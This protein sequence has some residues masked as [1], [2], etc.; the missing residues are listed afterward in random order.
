MKITR[1]KQKDISSL[2]EV[3][4]KKYNEEVKLQSKIYC[5]ESLIE[6]I[7]APCNI[8]ILDAFSIT[9]HELED[10]T[11]S[12]LR[13]KT[14]PSGIDVDAILFV[15][16]SDSVEYL[17][18]MDLTLTNDSKIPIKVSNNK[19][20]QWFLIYQEPAISAE[21]HDAAHERLIVEI[22]KKYGTQLSNED[23]YIIATV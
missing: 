12:E 16:E 11:D 19:E 21:E 13:T 9:G 4:E 23:S 1:F 10:W 6:S 14:L 18:I 5:S 20:T 3:S 22:N 15:E 2:E 8:I 17:Q 7:P